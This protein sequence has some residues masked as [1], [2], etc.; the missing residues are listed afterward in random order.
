MSSVKGL[1][2][3]QVILYDGAYQHTDN[4]DEIAAFLS[5][6]IYIIDRVNDRFLNRL[7]L[8]KDKKFYE[9]I[10]DKKAVD[11]MVNSGYNPMALITFLNK[12]NPDIKF[13]LRHNPTNKRLLN[14]YEYILMKY[15][16]YNSEDNLYLDNPY[17][18][19]F[20]LNT[21]TERKLLHRDILKRSGIKVKELKYE[22]I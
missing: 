9:L 19:N 10:I 20:L 18:Q 14:I 1:S 3:H 16:Q 13:S 2:K 15:P 21:T 17:Y 4:D 6:E 12:T 7:N 11:Y 22:E 8:M 5:R